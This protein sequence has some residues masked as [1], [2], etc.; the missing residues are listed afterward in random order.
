MTD[1]KQ[2]TEAVDIYKPMS[3]E[4]MLE[5][6]EIVQSFMGKLIKPKIHYGVIPGCG[7]KPTLLQPGA[8]KIAMAFHMASSYK[9]ETEDIKGG[10]R[11][12]RVICVLTNR[13]TGLFV[14]EGVG[15]CSSNEG[16]YKFVTQWVNGKKEKVER[17]NPP[18]MYNTVLKMAK[19]RAYVDA[20]ITATAVSELFTQDLEDGNFDNKKKSE[21][22]PP[23]A[24][25][26]T[27][28]PESHGEKSPF[29]EKDFSK[30]NEGGE[31]PPPEHP[32]I[33][34]AQVR[35]FHAIATS[36]KWEAFDVSKLLLGY[37]LDSAKHIPRSTYKEIINILESGVPD[38][39]PL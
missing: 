19:K 38:D 37:E 30:E 4:A 29:A 1:D 21:P 26:E 15:S 5:Q 35:R 25:K 23:P 31:P 22:P 17:D 20:V 8:Q 2:E 39:I 10:G 14:G 18:D 32:V 9:I 11:E 36:N 16:K 3:V 34:E 24:H 7:D 13:Q 12:Y 28:P 33:S 27:P 6:V